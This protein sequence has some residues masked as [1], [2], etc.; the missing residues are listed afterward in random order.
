M[1]T[2][3]KDPVRLHLEQYDIIGELF[4]PDYNLGNILSDNSSLICESS[5]D[6]V[7]YGKTRG[8][9]SIAENNH[10][11]TIHGDPNLFTSIAEKIEKLEYSVTI[12]Y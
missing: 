11:V 8:Y 6:S 4:K 1:V 2:I 7:R 9:I 12:V 10:D 3:I 5:E